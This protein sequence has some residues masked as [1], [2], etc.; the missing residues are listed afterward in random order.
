MEKPSSESQD[1]RELEKKITIV[2][3]IPPS[4]NGTD[5][6]QFVSQLKEVCHSY[7]CSAGITQIGSLELGTLINIPIYYS[8]FTNI[9]EKIS[10]MSGVDKVEE[11]PPASGA[12]SRFI[13]TF[14]GRRSLTI[15]P[16]NRFRVTLREI[17]MAREEQAAV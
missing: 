8:S 13:K 5:L 1:L 4:T 2:L 7:L 17:C 16:S 9:L 6:F 12:V 15:N 3:A 14:A 10:G 11:Y